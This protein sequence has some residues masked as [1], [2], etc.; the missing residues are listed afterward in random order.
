MLNP[1]DQL[2][3]LT[4]SLKQYVIREAA[5]MMF[6]VTASGMFFFNFESALWG[7]VLCFV[8]GCY[9]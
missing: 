3:S 7:C 1:F 8:F 4:S 9:K 5:M 6:V 2:F